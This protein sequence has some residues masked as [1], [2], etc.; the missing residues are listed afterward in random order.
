MLY[1]IYF[2]CNK[3]LNKSQNY[4]FEVASASDILKVGHFIH[5]FRW[6]DAQT[7]MHTH[8]RTR[9]HVYKL[10]VGIMVIT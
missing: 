10:H 6:G 7:R 1:D 5:K 9:T 8:T 3:S 4:S 2:L